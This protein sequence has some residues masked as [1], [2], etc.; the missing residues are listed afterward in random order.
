M[1][2]RRKKLKEGQYGCVGGPLDR[3]YLPWPNPDA[4]PAHYL[5]NVVPMPGGQ[6]ARRSSDGIHQFWWVPDPDPA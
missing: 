3:L 1:S 6:Y 5:P 4:D 2:R